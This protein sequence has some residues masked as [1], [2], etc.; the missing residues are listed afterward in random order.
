MNKNEKLGLGKLKV[1]DL[2]NNAKRTIIGGDTQSAYNT[3]KGCPT[4]P[5]T[6]CDP[7]VIRTTNEAPSVPCTDQ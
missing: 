2:D 4:M 5:T 3:C 1:S 6:S 7:C